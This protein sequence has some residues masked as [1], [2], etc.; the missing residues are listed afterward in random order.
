MI[1]NYLIIG[2]RNLLHQKTYSIIN[3]F[4]LTIGLAAFLLIALHIQNELGFNKHIPENHRL[5]RC[6]EKQYAPGVGEQ[7]VAVSMGPLGKALVND[8]PEIVKSVRLMYWGPRPI[9]YEDNFFDQEF[10]V[11]SDP[12][13]FDLFGVKL[14]KGDTANALKEPK[15]IVI[16]KKIAEKI[17]GSIEN[18]MGKMVYLQDTVSFRVSG[19]MEDQPIQASFRMEALVP[20]SLMENKFEWLKGWNNNSL[21]TYVRLNEGVDLKELESKFPEFIANH[22]EPDDSDWH[23]ELYLQPVPDIHLKSEHI[24]FQ[25]MNYKQGNFNMVLAFSIIAGL[26]ILLACI[27]FVNLAI[28]RSVQRAKEVGMRKVVGASSTNLMNQFMGES[29]IITFI[30]I[31]LSVLLVELLLPTFNDI[32]GTDLLVDLTGNWIFNIGL[33]A[34]LVLVSVIAGSYPAFYLTRF[35][36][37]KVLKNGL[38]PED[39]SSNLLTK[40]LVVFQFVISIGMIFSIAVTSDQFRYAMNKDIGINYTDVLSIRLFSKNDE[41]SVQFLKNEFLKNPNVLDVS[42]VSEVN[43]VGGSQGPITVDD[44]TETSVTVR[45]GFVDY[46]FF[47]M[48]GI[49]II[50]GRN[51]DKKNSLDETESLIINRATVE[52]LGWENPIGKTF[53][54]FDDTIQKRKVIGVIEDYHYYSIHSKIEPAIYVINPERSFSLAVKIHS[55]NQE[56]TISS[57]E[58]IWTNQFPGLPFDY[59]MA[60]DMMNEYYAGEKST[61]KIFSFFTILSLIISCL[62]LYGLTS[63]MI[64]KRRR[65]IGIRKVFGGSVTQIVSLIMKNFMRL[66]I[67]AGIIATPIA[68]YFMD[69]ALDSFAYRIPISWVYFA[70]SIVLALLIATIT[71]VYHAMK[72]ARSNPVDSLRYE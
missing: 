13:V 40:G 55:N 21:D 31:I 24:K 37:I 39:S 14:I 62:G 4:G 45:Y 20:F 51:F 16:S 52:Y 8:F 48:M 5:Y 32:L 38:G 10:L 3:I 68:W 17:F 43:G 44:T 30:S 66:I 67:L 11:F 61:L 50:I 49:P 65:E 15:S 9:R 64:E 18:A 42:F 71:I 34:I 22:T 36:P 29:V 57:L 1:Y 69:R 47:E 56:K 35:Q 60:E 54:P 19:V 12:E 25:V 33:I 58:E 59:Q 23:W 41:A 6:V 53:M 46:N 70:E 72:A 27:N 28:A 26:I 63:L 7:H 2:I